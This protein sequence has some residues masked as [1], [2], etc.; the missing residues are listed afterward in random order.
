MGCQEPIRYPGRTPDD[1]DIRS[2][3]A[4]GRFDQGTDLRREKG[5][6]IVC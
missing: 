6:H 3:E 1:A 5:A 4:Q 2:R